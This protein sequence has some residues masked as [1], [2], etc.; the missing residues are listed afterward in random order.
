M[1]ISLQPLLP[2]ILCLKGRK[3][4]RSLTSRG[5]SV[6]VH[7]L[8]M[9][10]LMHEICSREYLNLVAQTLP[11][12]RAHH[13]QRLRCRADIPLSAWSCTAPSPPPAL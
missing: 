7:G 5:S 3:V 13:S 8:A 4:L 1:H 2:T 6:D 11:D 9:V 12:A 10:G